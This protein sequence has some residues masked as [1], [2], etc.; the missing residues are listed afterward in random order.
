[1]MS[2]MYF[3]QGEGGVALDPR[4]NGHWV[5]GLF[6]SQAKFI[7]GHRPKLLGTTAIGYFK[8]AY[9]LL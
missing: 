5:S 2:F 1:M 4:K 6:A 9:S 3:D 8:E 7:C